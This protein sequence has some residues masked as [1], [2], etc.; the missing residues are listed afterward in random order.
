LAINIKQ[1]K[2]AIPTTSGTQDITIAGFGTPKAALFILSYASSDAAASQPHAAM[3]VGAIDGTSQM[4]ITTIARDAQDITKSY[5]YA[6][7][8][9]CITL[10]DSVAGTILAE[11]SFSGWI[12]DGVRITWTD[13]APSAYLLTTILFNG[14]D[15]QAKVGVAT[16]DIDVN[17]S[18]HI[19][20]GFEPDQ[21]IVVSNLTMFDI[22]GPNTDGY[23]SLGFCDNG[24]VIKQTC[25]VWENSNGLGTSRVKTTLSN[26]YIY[27]FDFT[28]DIAGE[29][30]SF[31]GSGFNLTTRLRSFQTDIGY[32][33]LKYNDK[34]RHKLGFVD[35][36]TAI[37]NNYYQSDPG[38]KPQF[39]F[40]FQT[41][42]S[43]YNITESGQIASAFGINSL[44][45]GS[46]QFYQL[47]SGPGVGTSDERNRTRSGT[48]L[49]RSADIDLDI[50]NQSFVF[51]ASGYTIDFN[52]VDVNSV[53]RKWAYLAVGA[54][55]FITSGINL[56]IKGFDNKNNDIDLF[57]S[58]SVGGANSVNNDCDLFI[59]GHIQI[60]ND[61]DLFIYGHN[62]SN[63]NIN[64]FIS[65]KNNQNNDIDLF[66]NGHES[67]T[68]NIHLFVNGLNTQ[69]NDC[70]LFIQGRAA[71]NNNID[72]FIAGHQSISSNIDL[73]IL[74]FNSQNQNRN[75]FI[76]GN[77]S[78]NNDCDLSIRGYANVNN[79][80][81]LFINGQANNNND[82]DLFIH[83]F[84]SNNQDIDLFIN[85][86]ESQNEN[87]DLFVS[88]IG[89]IN[90]DITL[91]IS[92]INLVSEDLELFISGPILINNDC[93]LFIKGLDNKNN[94][95][96][97]FINGHNT[98]NNDINLYIGGFDSENNDTDLFVSGTAAQVN[99]N[100]DL[101]INAGNFSSN[102]LNLFIRGFN[103]SNNNINLFINGDDTNS[104]AI[105][106]TIFGK[107]SENQSINLTILGF[108]SNSNDIDLSIIGH[109]TI[110]NDADLVI[111]GPAFA[112]GNLN[113][114]IQGFSA[115]VPS[116]SGDINLIINGLFVPSGV[117]CPILDPTASIQISDELI[118]IYQSRIDAL[119]NQLGKNVL[120]EFDP[121]KEP[122]TNCSF[123][124][125]KQKSNGI[126]KIG[127]PIPFDRGRKCPYC[128]GEGFLERPVT[129]C[130]QCLI[131]WNPK[132]MRNY[133]ISVSKYNGVVRL[134]TFLFDSDDLI[135]AKT[136]IVD[137]DIRDNM[138]LR[139]RL[140]KGPVPVGLRE[141]RYCISFWNLVDL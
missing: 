99:N 113:L 110:N 49:L 116:I 79:D 8:D 105:D 36:V 37:N 69:N 95:C 139:V 56:F 67:Q 64:L 107:D 127:G 96:D 138:H 38:F 24:D 1:V 115:V 132:E 50:R 111:S 131:K 76:N 48:S 19:N 78:N 119:I 82:I 100:V 89:F 45:S 118:G 86:N 133:G 94:D 9:Q 35:T 40:E 140:I 25:Q 92:S 85:G 81:D 58:G 60:N 112:S 61:I 91:F 26:Q 39:M 101:F 70:D 6:Q 136:A 104:N 87:I 137:Y 12:T 68:N 73:S 5:K 22:S 28:T 117:S 129:K 44:T 34:V 53:A 98:N 11:A 16:S 72:L 3:S 7:S 120:L 77:V 75:L 63:N 128:K 124:P 10:I 15:L 59:K 4:C 71:I 54:N 62:S 106:L 97:L 31:T 21:I 90:N 46:H 52:V 126:Y 29:I 93:D 47:H 141:D 80:L 108:D 114:F 14:S 18:I 57:V 88:G 122:C 121:V 41:F 30:T 84:A 65:G 55:N 23:L 83:G 66:I 102:S 130:I 109:V 74:G 125:I 134:K 33:A 135:R 20:T 103:T 123:D 42:H 27:T 43:G 2:A 32:L 51:A 13:P 17:D